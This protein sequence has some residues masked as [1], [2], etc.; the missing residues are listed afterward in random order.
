MEAISSLLLTRFEER[1][2]ARISHLQLS[3]VYFVYSVC[4]GW[5][6]DVS[7]TFVDATENCVSNSGILTFHQLRNRG[8]IFTSSQVL[9]TNVVR[10]IFVGIA[11]RLVRQPGRLD[12]FFDGLLE[13]RA[14]AWETRHAP[15]VTRL[16]DLDYSL[17][18]IAQLD[19]R[20]NVTM[21]HAF[22]R[23]AYYINVEIKIAIIINFN[24]KLTITIIDLYVMN[25]R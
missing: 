11:F 12:L 19:W 15:F 3:W 21:R 10:E 1:L 23:L 8:K 7:L 5:L 17:N 24:C 16:F 22:N 4:G 2:V 14:E 13:P 6:A 25:Q 18:G 20:N 9:H